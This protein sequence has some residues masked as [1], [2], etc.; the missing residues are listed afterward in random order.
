[1]TTIDDPYL[2]SAYCFYTAKALADIQDKIDDWGDSM[3]ADLWTQLTSELPDFTVPTRR[4]D[5]G[6]M[7]FPFAI[8]ANPEELDDKLMQAIS[9]TQNQSVDELIPEKSNLKPDKTNADAQDTLHRL[10]IALVE[11]DFGLTEAIGEAQELKPNILFVAHISTPMRNVVNAV[12]NK[13]TRTRTTKQE[14]EQDS[15]T[16][17]Q[18]D[19]ILRPNVKCLV[20]MHEEQI[21][22]E[23]RAQKVIENLTKIEVKKIPHLRQL[24]EELRSHAVGRFNLKQENAYAS[25]LKTFPGALNQRRH[26]D[27]D[28]V[29]IKLNQDNAIYSVILNLTGTGRLRLWTGSHILGIL[30]HHI[31]KQ[32][33]KTCIPN[34]FY[35]YQA[36]KKTKDDGKVNLIEQ[37]Y[38]YHFATHLATKLG[39][40]Q[41][42]FKYIEI[43]LPNKS[44][45]IFNPSLWH[46]GA[47][48]QATDTFPSYRMHLYLSCAPLPEQDSPK[49]TV[50]LELQ[51][52]NWL[53][54]CQNFL[55]SRKTD[56][57]FPKVKWSKTNV[58][59]YVK[60]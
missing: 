40:H 45:V 37:L 51:G 5:V 15:R 26:V 46:L 2:S 14:Q 36:H 9:R 27:A 44:Y 43:S 8:N 31:M 57:K 56:K 24:R 58:K 1:M 47:M 20:I 55:T 29:T 17:L 10:G 42:M 59:K 48:T 50:G 16:T 11:T 6:E 12:I 25:I 35:D 34:S 49:R 52:Q 19:S 53:A 32:D 54:G 13:T 22:D 18:Y 39:F 33:W 28:A 60:R 41:D 3:P 4:L 30:F 38:F 21:F 23:R 7:D